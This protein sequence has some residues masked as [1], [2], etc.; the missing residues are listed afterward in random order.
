MV[1]AAALGL[2]GWLRRTE[3]VR[4]ALAGLRTPP[5]ERIVTVQVGELPRVFH[6][7][8]PVPE[9]AGPLPLV[10][11]LHGWGSTALQQE[12]L[13]GLDAL[14]DREGFLTAHLEGVGSPQGFNAGGC[15]GE[16]LERGVDDVGF[17]VAVVDEVARL[18]R[19]DPRRVYALGMSN[20][21]FMAHRLACERADRFAAVASVAGVLGLPECRPARPVPVL[22][23]HGTADQLVA[24]AGGGLATFAPVEAVA[25]DWARR[26]GCPGVGADW[27][28]DRRAVTY[29]RGEARCETYAG[30]AGGAA[31]TLCRVEGGGH[32]W[33][34]GVPVPSLGHTTADLDATE[35]SWRFFAEH[36]LPEAR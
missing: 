3:A 26:D 10:L 18:A 27:G 4:L 11:E 32:T 15:C 23:I 21:G 14:A 12:R 30:C 2:C 13:S 36:P 22:Q 29:Q 16:A 20:G 8:R 33:P 9:P 35:A 7:H 6:L 5:V 17:A 1:V 25:H 28:A 19:V 34:G 24:W 31:V